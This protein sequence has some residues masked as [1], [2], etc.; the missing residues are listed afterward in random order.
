MDLQSQSHENQMRRTS[1][2]FER[3][4]PDEIKMNRSILKKIKQEKVEGKLDGIYTRAALP[5]ITKATFFS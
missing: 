5:T 2:Q 4:N 3:M 1:P